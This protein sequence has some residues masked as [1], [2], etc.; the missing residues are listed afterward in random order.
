MD[1]LRLSTPRDN[2]TAFQQLKGNTS[3]PPSFLYETH[4]GS[5]VFSIHFHACQHE[6]A[7]AMTCD[8]VLTNFRY[9]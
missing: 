5:R 1:V 4:S 2:E 9:L 7:R 6:L 8:H 3:T